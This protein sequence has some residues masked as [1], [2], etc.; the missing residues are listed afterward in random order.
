[1]AVS[2]VPRPSA[3]IVRR[4]EAATAGRAGVWGAPATDTGDVADA[5]GCSAVAL[6][7]IATKTP[8]VN[9]RTRYILVFLSFTI[10]RS[11]T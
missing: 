6:S 9:P 8:T 4:A 5:G 10:G 1:M 3:A 7:D 2:A 11:G